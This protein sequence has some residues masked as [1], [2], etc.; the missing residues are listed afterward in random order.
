MT[1][2]APLRPLS[3]A[4][5]VTALL[6]V[7]LSGC[8]LGSDSAA[9][10]R[11]GG[12]A[13]SPTSGGSNSNS[14]S[15]TSAALPSAATAWSK[16]QDRIDTYTSLRVDGRD[17]MDDVK[18]PRAIITGDLDTDPSDV[19][20]T[21]SEMGNFTLRRIGSDIYLKGDDAYWKAVAKDDPTLPDASSFAD[22]WVKAPAS[23]WDDNDLDDMSIKPIFDAMTDDSDPKWKT[24][25][26]DDAELTRDTVDG[27]DAYK[28]TGADGDTVVWASADG[29]YNLLKIEDASPGEDEF[30]L[31]SFSRWNEKFEV[32]A[33]KGALDLGSADPE[34]GTEKTI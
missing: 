34:S 30:A 17:A 26:S 15:A 6:A 7:T 28:I 11:S 18:A 21:S 9:P 23:T 27:V 32:T 2:T 22:R 33:P 4:S 31:A 3:M 10:S 8:T 1:T 12:T 13:A 25:A 29:K 24:L 5:A 20:F 16:T 19:V 14:S